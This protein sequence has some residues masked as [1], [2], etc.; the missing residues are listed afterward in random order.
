MKYGMPDEIERRYS[1]AE[2]VPHEIWV[3]RQPR[4]DIF[5]FGDLRADGRFALLHCTKENEVHNNGWTAL[6]RK[7]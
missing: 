7:L 3:Y 4:L 1:E 5:V 6:I 2:T